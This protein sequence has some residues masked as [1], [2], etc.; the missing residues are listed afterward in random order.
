MRVTALVSLSTN[1]KFQRT[2]VVTAVWRD[3]EK[4]QN[5]EDCTDEPHVL[6]WDDT[7]V[8]A[9]HPPPHTWNSESFARLSNCTVLFV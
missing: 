3:V 8:H 7:E 5:D 4:K 6:E 9:I 1:H 2:L